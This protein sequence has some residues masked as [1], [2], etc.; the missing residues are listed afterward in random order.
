V[1][2]SAQMNELVTL[3]LSSAKIGRARWLARRR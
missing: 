1:Y 2:A 3:Y